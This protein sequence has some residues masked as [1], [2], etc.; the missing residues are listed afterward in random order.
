MNSVSPPV[1][2]LQSFIK[3]FGVADSGDPLAVLR[4]LGMSINEAM[5]GAVGGISDDLEVRLNRV[6]QRG[7]LLTRLQAGESIGDFMVWPADEASALRTTLL[8]SFGDPDYPFGPFETFVR[9]QR[10]VTTASGTA[11]EQGTTIADQADWLSDYTRSVNELGQVVWT[12]VS[13]SG[14]ETI[15]FTELETLSGVPAPQAQ[16]AQE[17]LALDIVQLVVDV[18]ADTQKVRFTLQEWLTDV[19]IDERW[20]QFARG[21]EERR[22]DARLDTQRHELRA[23]LDRL[24]EIGQEPVEMPSLPWVTEGK[25]VRETDPSTREDDTGGRE[26]RPGDDR[27]VAWVD[28]RR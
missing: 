1:D 26:A 15:V 11:T 14:G 12:S 8:A 22:S 4:S 18:Q 2:S 5:A 23:L 13:G 16:A 3:T 25:A 27:P 10:E 17:R 24:H 9:Y 20:M 21:N 28:P 7:E 6:E 19:R